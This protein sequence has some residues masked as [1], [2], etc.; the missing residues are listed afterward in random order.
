[1]T[2]LTPHRDA[3]EAAYASATF[4]STELLQ[5]WHNQ[6]AFECGKAVV[7]ALSDALDRGRTVQ[8]LASFAP[9]LLRGLS[10]N[11]AGRVGLPLDA[12]AMLLI[13]A[14]APEMQPDVVD[15]QRVE[16]VDGSCGRA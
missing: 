15:T 12:S 11:I 10:I 9:S 2:S 16:P 8:E 1:M 13:G 6:V 5:K 7:L 4:R 14:L 3:A